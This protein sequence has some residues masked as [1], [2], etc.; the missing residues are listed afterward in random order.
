MPFLEAAGR[1]CLWPISGSGAEMVVC[2]E[3]RTASSAY[4]ED[5]KRQSTP[6]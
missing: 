2:G 4:C 6:R 5:H 3:K 1:R